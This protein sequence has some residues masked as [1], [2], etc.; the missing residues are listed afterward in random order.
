MTRT[1]T[2]ANCHADA[3]RSLL[4]A[5]FHEGPAFRM[6]F[7]SH[8]VAW[9]KDTGLRALVAYKNNPAFRAAYLAR[10]AQLQAEWK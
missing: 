1:R 9:R 2:I 3:V 8:V 10:K 4:D 7:E 5:N 6:G